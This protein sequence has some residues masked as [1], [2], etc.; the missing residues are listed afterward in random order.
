[1]KATRFV[2]WTT[3]LLAAGLLA[4][5]ALRR[6]TPWLAQATAAENTAADN[7]GGLLQARYETAARLLD[8]EEK[9][10]K[11]GG[12]T[13]AHV[14]EA[15][16][17]VR[18]SAIELQVPREE[19]LR[20]LSNYLAVTRDLETNVQRAFDNGVAPAADRESA[21]YLRLDAEIA[22]LRTQQMNG[23]VRRQ[24]SIETP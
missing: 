24:R 6:P 22:L 10:L 15:A 7:L 16:R 12:T 20:A 8:M 21:R 14:C 18:D 2:P 1:M 23:G 19:Q 13:L 17:R 5:L 9:R 3:A 4:S 11:Q